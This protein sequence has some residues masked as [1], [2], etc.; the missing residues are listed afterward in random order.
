MAAGA[1]GDGA[2]ERMRQ[3]LCMQQ[4][5]VVRLQLWGQIDRHGV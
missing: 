2:F 3:R 1:F 4:F 5:A